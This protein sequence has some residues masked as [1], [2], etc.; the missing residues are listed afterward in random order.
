[1]KLSIEQKT[2]A[3]M[4]ENIASVVEKRNTLLALSNVAMIVKDDVLTMKATDLDIEY[5][6]VT[7]VA[8]A[9]DGATTVNAAMFGDIV[10]R[11]AS[12]SLV[13]LSDTNGQLAIKAGRS[14][15]S[16]PTL[17]IED[18]P[19]MASSEYDVTFDIPAHEISR[20]FGLARFAMSNEEIRY[21]LCGIYL[22]N[23]SGKIRAVATDGH[24]FALADG[25]DNSDFPGVIV[26]AK[27]VA[28]VSKQDAVG[29]VQVSVSDTKIKFDYGSAVI[30]SKVIDGTFPDYRRV[31]P[32]GNDNH[33]TMDGAA[34]K[35]ASD[36]VAAVSTEKSKAVNLDVAADSVTVSVAGQSGSGKDV[37]DAVLTGK[38]VKTGFNARYLSEVFAQTSGQ[39]TME[40]DNGLGP[41]IIRGDDPN[42]FWIVMPLRT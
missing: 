42:A 23:E 41:A 4:L 22:H 16:L 9:T 14:E 18:Y 5:T 28:E 3:K 13:D 34:I 25:P 39:V 12:G 38:P 36:R 29:D 24:K 19:F 2:L 6:I 8:G 21:Y 40:L 15:F 26:P 37:I 11:L 33:V 1:M 7:P 17:P 20:L 32:N 35:A 31:I 30:V 27:T 10:K